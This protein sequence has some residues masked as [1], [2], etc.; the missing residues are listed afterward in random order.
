MDKIITFNFKNICEECKKREATR[1]CDYIKSEWQWCGHP[2]K[3]D[4]GKLNTDRQM[5]GTH[6]CDAK[7]CDKCSTR[8]GDNDYCKEH[9]EMIKQIIHK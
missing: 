6:T 3:Y 2:P 9:K 4:N 8:I 1:L 7:L 5:S